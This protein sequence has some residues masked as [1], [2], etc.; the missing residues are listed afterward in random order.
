MNLRQGMFKAGAAILALSLAAC[1][2]SSNS[3]SANLMVNASSVLKAAGQ[4][5]GITFQASP[6]AMVGIASTY[7]LNPPAG[8]SITSV[9]WDFGDNSGLETGATSVQHTYYDV[10]TVNL[11]ATVVDS[12]GTQ[13]VFSSDVTV[14]AYDERL[15]CVGDLALSAPDNATVGQAVT[16]TATIPLCISLQEPVVSWDFGDGSAATNGNTAS[17]T[18]T[19]GGIYTV[20]VNIY[21]G[22]ESTPS[23]TLSSEIIVTENEPTPS[24]SPTPDPGPAPTPA[25]TPGPTPMPDPGPTPTPTPTPTPGPTPTPAPTPSPTPGPAPSPTPCPSPGHGGGSDNGGGNYVACIIVDHGKSLKLGLQT[26]VHGVSRSICIT[27]RECLGNVTKYF[28]V[29]GAY[30]RGYCNHNPNVPRLTDA[31]VDKMLSAMPRK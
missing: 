29:E 20:S 16:G 15:N 21:L 1:N 2:S 30:D 8:V 31:E 10:G 26:G 3:G 4:T 22:G 19:S 25:P 7:T 28:N 18:Y 17:H 13:M 23:F 24:P 11:T 9:T 6:Y 5:D 12:L 27:Q 14:I